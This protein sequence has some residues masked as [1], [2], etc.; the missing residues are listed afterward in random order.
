[1]TIVHYDGG[2]IE[3]QVDGEPV[4]NIKDIKL[5]NDDSSI[6]SSFLGF[7]EKE[8]N[9]PDGFAERNTLFMMGDGSEN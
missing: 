6:S 4:G 2:S 9:E 7:G 5:I 8:E 3:I 1:M